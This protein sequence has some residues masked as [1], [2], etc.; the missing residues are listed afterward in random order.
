M[1]RE[2]L[3]PFEEYQN[4]RASFV[5]TIAQ[6]SQRPQNIISLHSAG[7]MTLLKP[8]LLDSVQ[9]IQ[10]SAALAIGRLANY[11][12]EIAES[13]IQNDILTQLI[14]SLSNQNRFYKKAACYVIRAVAKHSATLADDIIKSGA[15][16]PLI[17]N[18]IDFDSSVKEAAAWA[19][20]Y[21]AKHNNVL[22]NMVVEAGAVDSLILCLHE[23]EINLKRAAMQT[24]SYI[25]QHSADLAF[26]VVNAG[27]GIISSYLTYNDTQ[28]KRNLCQLL[29]NIA[30][31][32]AELSDLVWNSLKDPKQLIACLMNPDIQVKKNTAFCICELVNKG[33][34]S[35]KFVNIGGLGVLSRFI[36]TVKG[37]PR[38]YGIIALGYIAGPSERSAE[39][40]IHVHG[41]E[42]L[43]DALETETSTDI[44]AA[45]CYS[46]GQ[47][48]RHSPKHANKVSENNTLQ[49]ILE[50]YTSRD[51]SDDLKG[52]AK[53]SLRKII[54]NVDIL[55]FLEPFL[56]IAPTEIMK[57]ILTQYYKHLKNTTTY[58]KDFVEHGCLKILQELKCN[59]EYNEEM[60]RLIDTIC[61]DNYDKELVN[62]Y[63]PTY[64]QELEKK[65][66]D[67]IN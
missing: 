60:R 23:P 52:K 55:H 65:F 46:L 64:K 15:L 3:Q 8:L 13:V 1:S 53:R 48:G 20:G 34:N 38:L 66:L 24:L 49:L 18:L 56:K 67:E 14:Y 41:I 36:A 35:D 33:D 54:A 7:V 6:L 63:S 11:S 59:S 30:K 57:L 47:I 2:L 4:A 21:I 22:A 32:S 5:Q 58:K 19:I 26:R 61:F 44:K 29:G 37:E 50:L 51:T 43:R 27:L 17:H 16:A 45:A 62:Y 12:E 10:Q 9:A 42:Y 25:T 28:L 39:A 40:I 31:H